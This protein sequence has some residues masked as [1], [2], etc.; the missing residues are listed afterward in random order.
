MVPEGWLQQSIRVAPELAGQRLDRFLQTRFTWRSRAW[1]QAL[2]RNHA[3]A[4]DGRAL[5]PA[6]IVRADETILIVFPPKP[7]PPDEPPFEPTVL[8]EDERLF[9]LD[10]PAGLPVHARGKQRHRALIHLLRKRFPDM[11]LDLAHRL[12]RETSGVLLFTKDQRAN[13]HVKEQLRRGDV[14]KE[15]LTLTH[16]IPAETEFEVSLPL[17]P[18]TRS[19][20]RMKMETHPFGLRSLTEFTVRARFPALGPE[21]HGRPMGRAG[22]ALVHAR[23]RTGRQHQIRVHLDAVGF[24]VVGDKIYGVPESVFLSFDE[25]GMDA[26]MMATLLLERHALHACATDFMHPSTGERLRV[27]SPL[28]EDMARF[29]ERITAGDDPCTS[30]GAASAPSSS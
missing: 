7:P 10:K 4:I 28:P 21:G 16:G 2:V 8:F 25:R 12:D 9:V 24:P 29:L 3:L 22:F 6:H 11:G 19:A 20:I 5:K 13:G 15:Y 30:A 1:V 17:R 23:P 27:E 26:D 14:H 18:A